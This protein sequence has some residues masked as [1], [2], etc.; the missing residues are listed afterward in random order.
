MKFYSEYIPGSRLY[1]D[2]LILDGRTSFMDH[3]NGFNERIALAKLLDSAIKQRLELRQ[4]FAEKDRELRSDINDILK[5]I[6]ILDEEQPLKPSEMVKN[7]QTVQKDENSSDSISRTKYSRIDYKKTEKLLVSYIQESNQPV[8]LRDLV[9]YLNNSHDIYFT[10][11]YSVINKIFSHIP[12][13]AKTKVGRTLY[14]SW[15]D[16]K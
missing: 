14:F 16:S 4:L 13:I 7:S 3:L 10:N 5:R 6:R 2:S 9:N 8:T 15:K 12:N 1:G 11:E